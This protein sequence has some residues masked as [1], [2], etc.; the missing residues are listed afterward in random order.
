MGGSKLAALGA[1]ASALGDLRDTVKWIMAAFTGSSAI[2]FSGLAVT[3]ISSLAQKG[4]WILPVA[5]AAIPLVAAVG[6]IVMALRVINAKSPSVGSI[7]PDYW[8]ALGGTV[9]STTSNSAELEAELP[10]AIGVYGTTSAFDLRLVDAVGQVKRAR[11]LLDGSVARQD[12]YDQALATVDGLQPTVKDALDCAAYVTAKRQFRVFSG[13]VLVATCIALA[14][15]IASGV[16]TGHLQH[17]QQEAASE[18]AKVAPPVPVVFH[19][20][21]PVQVWLT[22]RPPA[23]AGGSYA[24][25]LWNGMT[26]LA[27]GGTVSRPVLLFPGYSISAAR[28]HGIRSAPLKCADPW[29]WSTRAGEVLVEPR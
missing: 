6:A 18:A 9:G 20:P 22:S 2:V 27:V 19:T 17:S 4:Q 24:C 5:L 23:A 11:D 26:A 25:P 29:L 13:S 1:Y 15:L 7:F 14:G 12:G 16:V 21:T 8:S 3:N 28:R 10:N